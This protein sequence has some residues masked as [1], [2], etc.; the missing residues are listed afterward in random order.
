MKDAPLGKV[1]RRSGLQLA[2]VDLSCPKFSLYL[3]VRFFDLG[4]ERWGKIRYTDFGDSELLIELDKRPDKRGICHQRDTYR[5]AHRIT[6]RHRIAGGHV[7][8]KRSPQNTRCRQ[9]AQAHDSLFGRPLNWERFPTE[10]R[11]G[12]HD[13]ALYAEKR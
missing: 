7:K 3:A 6:I 12:D 8:R 1:R 5:Y 10:S 2:R 13:S 9:R 4:S 11:P